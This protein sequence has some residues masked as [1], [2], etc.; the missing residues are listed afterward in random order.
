MPRLGL[1]TPLKSWIFWWL[2]MRGSNHEVMGMS[3][4]VEVLLGGVKMNVNTDDDPVRVKAAAALVQEQFIALKQ[5]GTIIDSSKIMALIA[6]NLADELINQQEST[7]PEVME[8]IK[9]TLDQVVAQAEGLA[10]VSLR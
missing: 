5:S 4:S 3:E 9:S 2:K 7:N 6:L 10:N 8:S 1:S